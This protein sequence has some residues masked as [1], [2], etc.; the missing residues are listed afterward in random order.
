M[1]MGAQYIMGRGVDMPWIVDQNTM[2]R[3]VNILLVGGRYTMGR[4]LDI[5]WIGMSKCHG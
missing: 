1:A 2:D 5:P 4:K 3:G